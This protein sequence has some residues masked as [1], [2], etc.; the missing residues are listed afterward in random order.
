MTTHKDTLGDRMKGHEENAI[1]HDG[2]TGQGPV[3]IRLDGCAFHTWTKKMKLK[4][5]FDDVFIGIMQDTMMHL[6]K[7]IPSCVFGYCQSDEISLCL[8]NDMSDK[9]EPWFE[10]R[11]QK[12]CSVTASMAAG[13][14]NRLVDKRIIHDHINPSQTI[15]QEQLEEL[16]KQ[17]DMSML[18]PDWTIIQNGD[19]SELHC[20]DLACFDSRVLF[21][22]DLEEA[23]NHFIWR[24]NDC[25]RNSVQSM[26]QSLYSQKHLQ[27]KGTEELKQMISDKGMSWNEIPLHHQRGSFCIRTIARTECRGCMMDRRTWIIDKEPPII[28]KNKQY[29]RNSYYLERPLN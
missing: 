19:Y 4:T 11:I 12:I 7:S 26:A 29:L 5:P 21:M 2:E 22:P 8:R 20:F 24:Q 3:V 9:T 15:T 25:M 23:I 10:N 6:C 13:I 17:L 18:N 27:N 28:S 1:R 16:R 14:F